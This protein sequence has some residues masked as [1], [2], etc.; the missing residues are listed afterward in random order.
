LCSVTATAR[1]RTLNSDPIAGDVFPQIKGLGHSALAQRYAISS[2]AEAKAYLDH[3]LLGLRLRA[4][5][6]CKRR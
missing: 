3:T 6:L 4:D 5:S 1:R 2:L